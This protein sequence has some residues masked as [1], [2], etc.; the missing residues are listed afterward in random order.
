MHIDIYVIV[1]KCM[2]VDPC[3]HSQTKP[4]NR[5][6]GSNCLVLLHQTLQSQIITDR[7]KHLGSLLSVQLLVKYLL[8]SDW[9]IHVHKT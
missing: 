6:M 2:Y 1:V 8:P 9:I 7:S 5:M 4:R 3:T